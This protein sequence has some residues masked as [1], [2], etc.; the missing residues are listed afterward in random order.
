MTA[1]RGRC[2]ARARTA[3]G[4]AV[5]L[6]GVLAAAPVTRWTVRPVAGEARRPLP[7]DEAVA[8]ATVRWTHGITIPAGAAEVWAWL[9]QMGWAGG[10]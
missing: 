3:V 9:I 4:D 5:R 10:G 2:S 7:G 8:G 1:G 6:A